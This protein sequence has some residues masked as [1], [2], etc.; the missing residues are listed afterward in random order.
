MLEIQ[1]AVSHK[2]KEVSEEAFAEIFD[3]LD[4]DGDGNVDL[5]EFIS[6]VEEVE[7]EIDKS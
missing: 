5:I 2:E 1:E 3:Q 4:E 6:L 7:D